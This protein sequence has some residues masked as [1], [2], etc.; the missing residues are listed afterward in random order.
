MRLSHLFVEQK[1]CVGRQQKSNPFLR[2]TLFADGVR[3]GLAEHSSPD[4]AF[5]TC[6]VRATVV[7][8]LKPFA[9]EV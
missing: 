5:V 2:L 7:S 8:G 6:I 9:V 4:L 1:A 3:S